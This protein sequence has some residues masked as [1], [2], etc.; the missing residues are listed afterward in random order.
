MFVAFEPDDYLHSLIEV[1]KSDARRLFRR[2]IY[3]D[4]PLRGPRGQAACAYC[5]Q[6]HGKLTIDHIIPKSRGGPHFARWHLAPACERCNL[7]KTNAPV[8]EWWRPQKFW[9]PEKEEILTSWIYCNSFIDAHVDQAEY[10]QFLATKRVVQQAINYQVKTR[11]GPHHGPFSLSDL[12][13]LE[14]IMHH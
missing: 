2:A 12:D 8:F 10:W 9:T 11:K 4:Y 6:W 14:V 13:Q 7:S 5:G 1:R 3:N